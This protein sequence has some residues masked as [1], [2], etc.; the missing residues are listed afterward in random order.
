MPSVARSP[1]CYHARSFDSFD[2]GFNIS[3]FL[4]SLQAIVRTPLH[5][6]AATGDQL[7]LEKIL[8]TGADR[9]HKDSK[10]R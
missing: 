7:L 2:R 3:F 10:V 6:A 9:N 8:A 4:A 1:I 5:E